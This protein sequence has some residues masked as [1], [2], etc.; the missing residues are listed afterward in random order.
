MIEV[1]GAVIQHDG[2]IFACR[3][4][5]DMNMAGSWEF[6]GGKL[7][8]GEK[9][10]EALKREIEEELGCVVS[11]GEFI[12]RTEYEYEF[13]AIA[14]TSFFCELKDGSPTLSE[15]DDSGWFTPQQL[16]DLPWAPADV[17]AVQ[18]VCNSTV[19]E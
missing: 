9:P 13:G 11:V 6:P 14:L 5:P 4:G 12:T 8:P 3:R 18:I 1:V 15:H 16:K 7:E 19:T 17:E 10:E 2:K